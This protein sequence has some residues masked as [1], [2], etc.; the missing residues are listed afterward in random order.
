MSEKWD[1]RFLDLA[2]HIAEWSKDP[3][4]K[5]GAVIVDGQRRVVSTG[6]NGFA[7]NLKDLPERYDNRE[8]KYR[9]T[10]H[11]EMNCIHFAYQR[12]NGCSLYTYPFMSCSRCAASVI[13]V[14]ITR[15]VAPTLPDHLKERWGEDIAISRMMFAEAG[16]QLDEL[17]SV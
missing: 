1:R 10:I 2:K 13:Q 17:D 7:S 8:L 5:V 14:G 12:L 4:T 15:C 9:L 16:V 3:S 6:Y 11:A